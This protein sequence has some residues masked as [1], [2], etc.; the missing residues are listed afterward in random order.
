MNAVTDTSAVIDLVTTI[1]N[2]GILVVMLALFLRG[3][4]M[5]TKN[6]DRMMREADNRANIMAKNI[7]EGVAKEI[8]QSVADGMRDGLSTTVR[9]K[10]KGGED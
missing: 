8:R 5:S 2:A 1:A 3:D 9:D 7:V 6:V 4:L 10:L